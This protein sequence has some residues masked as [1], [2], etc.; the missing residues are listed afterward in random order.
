MP[1]IAHIG[2]IPVEEWLP[3]VAPVVVLC[4]YGYHRDRR[5]RAAVQQLP[6]ARDLL[7]QPTIERVL[8]LWVAKRH[9]DAQ[10]RHLPV[11]YPPG[12]DGMT[13][14]ALADR[15]HCDTPTITQ[16]LT[17]LEDSGY[18]EL[19]GDP[20]PTQKILLTIEGHDLVNLTERTLLAAAQERSAT[21]A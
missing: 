12:P 10:A 6:D 13:T 2:N 15:A 20:G 7:D 17:E 11:L 14:A 19:D 3:F 8:A 18:L 9:T 16:L 1:V 5:R 21:G 4:L